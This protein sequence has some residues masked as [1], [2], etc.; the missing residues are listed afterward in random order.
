MTR[1][2]K[3]GLIV[4]LTLVV[5]LFFLRCLALVVSNGTYGNN[6]FINIFKVRCVFLNATADDFHQA[7][8]EVTDTPRELSAAE[9]TRFLS[10]KDQSVHPDDPWG[11]AL[12]VTVR[13]GV[14]S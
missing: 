2:A 7:Q 10:R 5:L 4:C 11:G 8:I 3:I 6:A 1:K 12:Q 14:S 13:K 9:L